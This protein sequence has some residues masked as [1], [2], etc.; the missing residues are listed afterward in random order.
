MDFKF[1]KNCDMKLYYYVSEEGDSK[2][3]LG[4][5]GCGHKEEHTGTTC[6]YNNEYE[7]DLS[8]IIN[9]NKFLQDDITLPTIKGNQNMKCPN[10]ECISIK[11][12]KPSDII[13]IKYDY[14]SMKFSYICNY[15]KQ[16]W[17]N[18]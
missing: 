17:T 16:S 8:Q 9:Q 6:I 11:E 3:Y 1:C 15:C 18:Q 4:C 7:I 5:K 10:S 2:L 12:K 13:Y 14:D